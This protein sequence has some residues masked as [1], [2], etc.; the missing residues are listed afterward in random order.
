MKLKTLES[1][2]NVDL[3]IVYNELTMREAYNAELAVNS[4]LPSISFINIVLYFGIVKLE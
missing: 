4:L 3:L 1:G 2:P